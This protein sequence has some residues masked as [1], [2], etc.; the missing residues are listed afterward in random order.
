MLNNFFVSGQELRIIAPRVA[1]YVGVAYL[2]IRAFRAGITQVSR[3]VGVE[4]SK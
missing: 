4:E 3:L 1:L 2:T